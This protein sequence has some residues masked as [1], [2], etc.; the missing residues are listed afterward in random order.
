MQSALASKRPLDYRESRR[1]EFGSA[2][3]PTFSYLLR[4]ALWRAETPT[5]AAGAAFNHQTAN[6]RRSAASRL[7]VVASF[8]VC[9]VALAEVNAR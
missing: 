4:L 9:S 3:I 2:L 1:A 8:V 7:R 5:N 6:T